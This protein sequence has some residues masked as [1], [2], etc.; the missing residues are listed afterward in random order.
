MASN[1]RH[2]SLIGL[3][4]GGT[5]FMTTRSTLEAFP[6]SFF[7]GLLSGNFAAVTDEQVAFSKYLR[8]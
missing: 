8:V 1:E 4:V 3:N 6:G 7:S 5:R 2:P